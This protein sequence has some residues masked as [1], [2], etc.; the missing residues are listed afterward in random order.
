MKYFF[1]SISS[2][3]YWRYIFSFDGLKSIFAIYGLLW[4][5]IST[6]DFF[7]IYTRDEYSYYAFFIFIA[8][9]IILSII[10]RRP[11]KSISIPFPEYDFNI[12]VR[13]ADLFGM[14]GA[15]M[16]SSNTIFEADVAGGKIAVDSLQGQFTAKYYTGNQNG[17]I[18]SIN[19]KIN[20]IG[21]TPPYPMGTTIPIHTHGKTFYF[22]AMATMGENGNASST[23][24][25]IK[26]AL[27][28][29]WG[30]VRE[31]GE[32]QELAVPVIGTGRGRLQTT[33]KKMI[34]LIAESFVKAS[35]EGKFTDKLVITIRPEDAENFGI[36]LYD[37]KDHLMHVLK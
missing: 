29:L 24:T 2:M 13:I 31:K 32:L 1:S 20:K 8:I 27:N 14:G 15:T 17:L 37:I 9:S 11:I 23:L 35:I 36:N 25:D 19:E 18:N 4:L 26:N 6:L 10:L 34:A 21:L 30:Y 7:K 12:D 22:T 28:G 16:I 33:R 5:L 3:A